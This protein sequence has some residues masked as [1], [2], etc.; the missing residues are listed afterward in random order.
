MCAYNQLNGVFGS[1]NHWLLTK[2]LREEWGFEG[3]VMSDWGA[4]HDRVAS[5]NAGLNLEMPPS[6][7]DDEIVVAV[8]DGRLDEQQLDAMAQGM[9]DLV[10]KARAAMEREGFVFDKEAH[11][12]LARRAAQESIVLLK[13]EGGMLPLASDTKVAVI[14]EFARTP[15]Y[16]GGGSSHINPTK[17]TSFLDALEERGASYSFVPGFTLDAAE[18]D[19]QL[20]AQAVEAARQADVALVYMGLP[21]AEESEGFDRTHLNLPAKQI[22]I[23]S[24]VAAVNP[25]TVVAL[26]NG[27]AVQMNPWQDDAAAILETWLLGQAGGSAVADILFGDANPSGK[28]AQSFPLELTDDPSMV[29][30]PGGDRVVDYGEGVFVGYRYYDSF[31]V[32]VAYPFGFGLSYSNFE[33]NNVSV[34][35]TGATSAR[36]TATVKNTSDI[37]GAEVVQVYVNPAEQ[38][39]VQRPVHELKGFKKVF[40]AAGQSVDVE[41]ELD[42]RAFAYWSEHDGDWRVVPG[43]Y[44]VEVA[45][46]SRDIVSRETVELAGDDFYSTLNEWSNFGEFKKDPFGSK[47]VELMLEKGKTGELP[48]IPEDNL[49]VQLFLE[50]MPINSMPVLF[51]KEGRR[52]TQF[53]LDEYAAQRAKA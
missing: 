14:G 10:D 23:L 38:S 22:E 25:R 6:Y 39:P 11:H 12:D 37:D 2:V 32:N 18:Q 16:Q 53:L 26:S 40:V 21:E 15:R 28:L 27:S 33:I 51:G 46:S 30:W 50:T 8:R 17:M 13:N 4:V 44:G 9:L 52:L 20:T 36:V 19:P 3:I 48:A 42:D 31:N 7:T 29:N 41:I 34:D 47:A 5:L 45:T 1:E 35:V 49:G 43:T 24:R